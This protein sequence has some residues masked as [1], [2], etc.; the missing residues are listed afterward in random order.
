MPS[1]SKTNILF[2]LTD[3]QHAQTISALGN[4]HI[5]TPNIDRLVETGVVFE[6]AYCSNPLCSPSRSSLFT[7]HYPAE[8][9]VT[10]NNIPLRNT[11][12][13]MGHW[14]ALHGYDCTYA[15]KWH[16]PECY[17]RRIPGFDVISTGITHEGSFS[18]PLMTE[19]CVERLF[20][21]DPSR[22]FLMVASFMQPHDICAWLRLNRD[23]GIPRRYPVP[24]ED[25]PPLPANFTTIPDGEPECYRRKRQNNEPGFGQWNEDEWRYYLWN[26]YRIVELVDN[27]VGRLLAAL[28]ATG[29]LEDTLVVFTAD[30]GESCASHSLCRKETFYDESARV[31]LIMSCPQRVVPHRN[32]TLFSGVDIFPTLCEAAGLPIPPR[33]AGTSLSNTLRGA[34][35]ERDFIAADSHDL[36]GIMVRSTRFKYLCFA[37]DERREM[38]FDMEKDPGET[39]NLISDPAVGEIVEQHRSWLR[40]WW[41]GLDVHPDVLVRHPD[42]CTRFP[43]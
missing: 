38:L 40:Q 21:R 11:M 6:Q 31:P 30:H 29:I 1:P 33:L 2:I 43:L 13:T 26:Y 12:L 41:H 37:E 20:N 23:G 32:T 9:G 16:V 39:R 15:G 25:L 10:R 28:E 24:P 42:L 7:G 35:I 4:S 17:M 8:T 5:S 34:T 18:D 27:E 19:A 36:H 3:Q 14:F 22:P